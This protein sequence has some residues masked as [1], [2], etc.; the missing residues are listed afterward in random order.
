MEQAVEWIMME[1]ETHYDTEGMPNWFVRFL[2]WVGVF[3]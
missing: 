3:I 1:H 2:K